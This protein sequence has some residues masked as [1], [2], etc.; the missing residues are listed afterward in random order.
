M[1]RFVFWLIVLATLAVGTPIVAMLLDRAMG[2]WSATGI[3]HDGS[4]TTIAFDRTQQRPDWIALPP[5]ASIVQASHVV[6][7]RQRRDVYLMSFSTGA[8]M[9]DIHDFY[10]N[11]LSHAGFAV[12][13]LGTGVMNARTAAFLGVADMLSAERSADGDQI[14]ITIRTPEGLFNSTLVELKWGKFGS[15]PEKNRRA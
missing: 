4:V 14:A 10:R 11:R 12:T 15:T 3:E 8:R 2:P 6:N 7:A 5:G 9:S 1:P 13:D